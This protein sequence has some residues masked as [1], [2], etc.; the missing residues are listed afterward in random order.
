MG[1][2]WK[3]LSGLADVLQ[4]ASFAGLTLAGLAG[5]I[6]AIAAYSIQLP[7]FWILMSAALLAWTVIF[8]FDRFHI[9]QKARTK[10][11]PSPVQFVVPVEYVPIND[12]ARDVYGKTRG[13]G[14][15]DFIESVATHNGKLEHEAVLDVCATYIVNTAVPLFG[16]HPPSIE[17]EKLDRSIFARGRIENGSFHRH[18]NDDPEFTQYI[19]TRHGPRQRR[20]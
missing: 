12:V 5:G 17:W 3:A 11:P 10:I 1:K 20:E 8:S 15:C 4:V 9:F 18:G 7:W 16:K 19:H 14:L 6:T 13:T 2:L